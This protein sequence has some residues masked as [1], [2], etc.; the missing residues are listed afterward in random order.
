MED[1]FHIK[2]STPFY[3]ENKQHTDKDETKVDVITNVGVSSIQMKDSHK[4]LETSTFAYLTPKANKAYQKIEEFQP[5]LSH[6]D[7]KVIHHNEEYDLSFLAKVEKNIR[8]YEEGLKQ[9]SKLLYVIHLISKIFSLFQNDSLDTEHTSSE[10]ACINLMTQLWHY[11]LSSDQKEIIEALIQSEKGEKKGKNTLGK[12]T[13]IGTFRDGIIDGIPEGEGEMVCQSGATYKGYF[14]NGEP[15]G[16]G[17]MTY[18][19]GLTY[20]GNFTNGN[21]EGRGKCFQPNGSIYFGEYKDNQF[22]KGEVAYSKEAG[23]GSFFGTFENERRAEGTLFYNTKSQIEETSLQKPEDPFTRMTMSH[24]KGTFDEWEEPYNGMLTFLNGD[25][26]KY[27]DGNPIDYTGT[28]TDP[29]GLQLE[30]EKGKPTDGTLV[31]P[32]KEKMEYREGKPY[33]GTLA[34]EDGTRMR[35]ENGSPFTGTVSSETI[36]FGLEYTDGGKP[37]NGVYEYPNG[38]QLRYRNGYP[39]DGTLLLLDG[40]RVEYKEDR[41]L[42]GEKTYV[43]QDKM[44]FINGKA[45]DGILITQEGERIKYTKGELFTGIEENKGLELESIKGRPYQG[46]L[47]Y[48]NGKTTLEYLNGRPYHGTLIKANGDMVTYNKGTEELTLRAKT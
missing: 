41:L 27:V 45:Y 6:M 15:H 1:A 35:Y 2:E 12:Y 14:L 43:S 24:F 44:K 17:K 5:Q 9:T 20:I 4:S 28:Y 40:R 31:N 21:V 34:A 37:W 26:V 33:T 10:K 11:E 48:P 30:Y 16:Y 22:Q 8:K 42:T 29:Q 23:G 39:T 32:N 36:E 19:N 25:K 18:P 3:L 47:T 46:T 7:Y 38:E 13:Y